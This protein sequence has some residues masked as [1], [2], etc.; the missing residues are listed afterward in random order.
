[1][2]CMLQPGVGVKKYEYHYFLSWLFPDIDPTLIPPSPFALT[3]FYNL[4]VDVATRLGAE[5]SQQP[6]GDHSR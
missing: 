6:G 4:F 2:R 1:M 5:P 3:R